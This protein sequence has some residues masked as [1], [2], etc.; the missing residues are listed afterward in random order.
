[1]P[2]RRNSLEDIMSHKTRSRIRMLFAVPS[3]AVLMLGATQ[4]LASPATPA[5]APYCPEFCPNHV[6]YCRTYPSNWQCS[7]C[8]GCVDY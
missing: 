5:R 6:E 2:A 7:Y 8:G 1:M 3:A 4:A